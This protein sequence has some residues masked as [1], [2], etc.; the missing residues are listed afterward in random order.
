MKKI[1]TFGP[2]D[3][4]CASCKGTGLY[5]GMAERDGSAVVCSNCKGTGKVT[6]T[7]TY[8]EFAERKPITDVTRVFAGSFG[9]V[10][11]ADDVV[12]EDG[13]VIAFSKGGCTYE[14]FLNGEEPKPVKELYCPYA[15]TNQGMQED[16]H[17]DH[18]FYTENCR[19]VKNWGGFIS[20]CKKYG[21]KSECWAL[22][23]AM[24]KGKEKA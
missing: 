1:I 5:R 22:Y 20:D 23:E 15:W 2:V 4:V 8:E 9:Y 16:D 12:A 14:E 13:K 7:H 18:E 21:D 10:H 3:V 6:V 24:R 19:P 11:A 17:P